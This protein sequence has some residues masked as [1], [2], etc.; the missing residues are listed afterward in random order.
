MNAVTKFAPAEISPGSE[1]MLGSGELLKAIS[2][3]DWVLLASFGPEAKMS[4]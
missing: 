4:R 2:P 1:R 3:P